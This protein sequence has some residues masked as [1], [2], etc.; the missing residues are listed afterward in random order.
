MNSPQLSSLLNLLGFAVGI[1]LYATLMMMTLRRPRN[2]E[3]VRVDKLLLVTAVLG[4]L[5]NFGELFAHVWQDL[6]NKPLTPFVPAIANAA[7]GF[8]PAVVVNSAQKNDEANHTKNGFTT[9]AAYF[10]SSIAA[11]WHFYAAIFEGFAPSLTALQVLTFGYL[12]ILAA[13]FFSNFR[14]TIGRKAIWATALS[15]FAI[16]A[17]HLSR[18]DETGTSIFTELIGHQAA[19][20][21]VIAI[22]LQDFRFAFADLFLKRALSLLMLT[23]TAFGLYVFAVAPFLQNR[24]DS[25]TVFVLLGAW[26][27]T[28]LIYPKLHQCAVWSVDKI[29]LRRVNYENLRV[30]VA[31]EINSSETAENV[32][33]VV[34]QKLADALTANKKGWRE[35]FSYNS[36]NTFSAVN[37]ADD[38]ARITLPTTEK[39]IY[40]IVLRNFQG[41]RRLLS[42][43]IQMLD[44]IAFIAA[45]RIDV[46]RV[47]HERCEQEIR[48]QSIGKLASEAELRALRAQ[49]NPH[50]LFNA[51]TTIGYLI[52]TSPEKA[53]ETL[54][55]LTRLLR[56]VLRSNA[57][58][59]TLGDEIEFIKSYLD[60][61]KARFEE[62]LTVKVEIARDLLN[63]RVPTLILQPL[64]ENAIKHGITPKKIGGEIRITARTANNN[65]ILEVTDTGANLK[66]ELS[67]GIGLTNIEQRL[68]S[69]FGVNGRLIIAN[70]GFETTAQITLPLEL[71]ASSLKLET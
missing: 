36:E 19:L 14:Q 12:A 54:M 40:E 18:N 66:N 44:D 28:A 11:I 4:L 8:L 41:G 15:V 47:S 9:I 2:D 37:F 5:W 42:D 22:L 52:Q 35:S 1:A 68:R 46:L 71:K 16:S 57:E 10:L 43:E 65:L 59:T 58:F 45:R 69:H 25:Q 17:L 33:D 24:N 31:R 64:V 26:I 23:A 32:L 27:L 3:K 38:A 61:E 51:L 7:L 62:R 48:Q 13:L 49:L 21:L 70:N 53:S 55:R 56:G 20:P 63:L 30:R 67:N 50:F 6:Q 29:I 39:P 34:S 60:I